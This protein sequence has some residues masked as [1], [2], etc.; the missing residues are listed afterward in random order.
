MTF[1]FQM[2]GWLFP[3]DEEP[4]SAEFFEAVDD[5]V[6]VGNG[7]A[8][9]VLGAE[10]SRIVVAVWP[11][12]EEAVAWAV[13]ELDQARVCVVPPA[14][15]EALT[16]RAARALAAGVNARGSYPEGRRLAQDGWMR[17]E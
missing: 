4:L 6:S 2:R 14:L 13:G 8:Y 3:S 16:L 1:K 15:S 10:D 11:A 9:R 7:S 17:D 12:D 5:A